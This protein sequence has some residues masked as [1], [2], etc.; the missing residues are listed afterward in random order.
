MPEIIKSPTSIKAA[1]NVVKTILEYVGCVNTKTKDV[2][3]AMMNSPKGWEEPGQTPEFDEYTIVLEGT[4]KAESED[5]TFYIKS[6]ETLI[7]HKGKWIR[8]SSP[9]EDSRYMAV[10][11]PAFSQELVHRDGE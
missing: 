3:I 6:G 7:A 2:S 10:C 8:Y 1:G 11:I 9:G 4:L 5:S